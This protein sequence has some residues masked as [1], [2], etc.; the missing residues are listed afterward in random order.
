MRCQNELE[1]ERLV[2]SK[3]KRQLKET[4]EEEEEKMLLFTKKVQQKQ[5]SNSRGEGSEGREDARE[6]R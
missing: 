2:T 6:T 1:M 4:K 3:L 5:T